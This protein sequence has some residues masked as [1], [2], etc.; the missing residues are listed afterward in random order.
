V[1]AHAKFGE[2][3]GYSWADGRNFALCCFYG[4]LRIFKIKW[5]TDWREILHGLGLYYVN[6]QSFKPI[7]SVLSDIL[8]P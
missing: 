7:V 3:P 2:N 6:Q 4:H 8:G 1:T 5:L